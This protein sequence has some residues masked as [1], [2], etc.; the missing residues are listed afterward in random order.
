M[1][2]GLRR[3]DGFGGIPA[4]LTRDVR[5]YLVADDGIAFDLWKRRAGER[6]AHFG[7]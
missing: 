6:P 1:D 2:A 7:R 5:Y 3:H 4:S